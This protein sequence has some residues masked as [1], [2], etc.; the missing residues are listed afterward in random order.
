MAVKKNCIGGVIVGKLGTPQRA[1][2]Y[3]EKMKKCPRLLFSM[4]E[5]NTLC[6][7]CVVSEKD[8][9]WLKVPER[10]P[11]RVGFRK[12]EVYVGKYLPSS[13]SV[14]PRRPR[15][16]SPMAPCGADCRKCDLGTEY[17]CRGC[18]ATTYYHE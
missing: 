1:K 3:V 7:V 6:L 11:R 8:R 18:P 9:S 5:G 10:E 4:V 12:A 13:F 14:V 16:G 2:E 15:G 17:Q